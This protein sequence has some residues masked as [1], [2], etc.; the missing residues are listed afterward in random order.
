MDLLT[1][2]LKD[3]QLRVEKLERGTFLT[4]LTIPSTGYFVIK[5]VTSDPSSPKTNEIWINS[6]TNQL[7]W[8]TGS[9]TKAVT[10]S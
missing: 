1:Q 6:S 4:K 10:L 8:Y 9:A 2:L 7:K 5:V 3:L